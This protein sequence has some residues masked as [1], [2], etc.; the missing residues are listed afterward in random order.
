MLMST[1]QKIKNN[2]T[3]VWQM[4]AEII[5]EVI[6]KRHETVTVV[7]QELVDKIVAGGIPTN[8]YTGN[9]AYGFHVK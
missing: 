3:V 8:H 5:K 1:D 7:L 9:K 2:A 6:K 4:G